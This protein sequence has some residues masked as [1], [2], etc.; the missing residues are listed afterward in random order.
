M[1]APSATSSAATPTS[2][3]A[4]LRLLL[5]VTLVG[6]LLAAIAPTVH[7]AAGNIT[8]GTL[9]LDTSGSSIQAHGGGMI[10]V[11]STY[12]WVG[13][14]RYDD[15][16]FKAVSAYASEDLVN[17]RSVGNILS[18]ASAAEL[19]HCNIERPK[20]I[21]NAATSKYVLWMH[22]ENGDNY[23]EA[24]TAV[25]TSSTVAGSYTYLS[26][27]RPLGYDSRDMTVFVDTDGTGYLI[28]A[29]NSNAD[30]NIYT[31]TANY[32][33]VDSLVTTLWSGSYRE[34]PALF[35]RDGVYFLLTSGA[36]YWNPNQQKY[37]TASSVAGPWTAL[38]NVGNSIAQGSQTAF[39]VAFSESAYLYM[40]DR[41]APAWDG[42]VDSSPYVWL[43]LTFPNSTAL[44]MPWGPKL[45]IDVA[46]GTLTVQSSGIGSSAAYHYLEPRHSSKCLDVKGQSLSENATIDQWTCNSG[47]N[48]Q[49][50]IFLIEAVG[51]YRLTARNSDQCLA[52]LGGAV[53]AG[54]DVVQVTCDESDQS[55]HWSFTDLGTGYTTITHRTSSLCLDV[56]GYSTS[57]GALVDLWT[58]T[59]GQNQQWAIPGVA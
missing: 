22:W 1:V 59:G 34:A 25:A 27:F 45:A 10:K 29:T 48:Q 28:S 12:Y 50:E 4:P 21:Y 41:W 5:R 49:F 26:S 20:I 58:C 43:P 42:T 52:P 36:T 54:T 38:Q 39:V 31:L 8:E 33:A 44:A 2:G 13:E 37:G 46:A 23:T 35:K 47:A 32:T 15:Q 24:R 9:F 7:A 51:Y 6:L 3:M 53:A 56:V 17:W 40:G 18:N 57:D 19:N 16:T 30:L 55:Q 11:G 14:N